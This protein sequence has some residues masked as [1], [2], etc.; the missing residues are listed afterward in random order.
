MLRLAPRGPALSMHTPSERIAG[1]YPDLARIASLARRW[2]FALLATAAIA[3]LLAAA[4]GSRA[5]TTY[6]AQARLLV[7]PLDA[8]PSLLR[9]AGQQAQTLSQLATS[10]PVLAGTRERLGRAG[11]PDLEE[12]L[13]ADATGA[14]RVLVITAKSADPATAARTANATAAELQEL[15]HDPGSTLVRG[16]ALA[17]GRL[18]LID[19]ARV[20]EDAL[21]T[22]L[23]P[24]VAS[25]ALA[26]LLAA[27][28]VVL[29]ADYFRGRIGTEAELQ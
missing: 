9:A 23:K 24:L 7:G 11:P 4:A 3:G 21:G 25:A 1:D 28:A 2:W 29:L 22:G 16:S 15:M 17:G 14:T 19:P 12:S 26:G 13:R 18:R 6:E 10:R 8:D 27:L 5:P 20:P